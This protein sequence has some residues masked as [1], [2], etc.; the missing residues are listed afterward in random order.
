MRRIAFL[1]LA[2]GLLLVSSDAASGDQWLRFE[3]RDIGLSVRF[4]PGWHVIPHPLTSC[5]DPAEAI[6]IGGPGDALFMLQESGT[7]GL[8]LRPTRFR[9][10][11]EPSPLECCTPTS[12]PGWVISFQE[13][14]R[15]FYAHLYPGNLDRRAEVLGILSSLQVMQR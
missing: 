2:L 12:D 14:G 5:I 11:G 4:P 13:H 1:V 10:V 9:L 15:G 7:R 3:Q 6:D 8:P